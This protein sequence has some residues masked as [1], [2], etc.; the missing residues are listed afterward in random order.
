MKST[1]TDKYAEKQAQINLKRKEVITRYSSL[2][3]NMIFNWSTQGLDD[4]VWLM[5]SANYLFRTDNVRW[6][7]DP[8][9]LNWRIPYAPEMELCHDLQPLSF[10]LLTHSHKDHLDINL[11]SSLQHLP[12]RW[13]IPE[14]LLPLIKIKVPICDKQIIV[15][16]PLQPIEFEGFRITPF[17]G[18]HLVTHPDGTQTGVPEMGYMVEYKDKRWLFPGDTRVYDAKLFPLFGDIDILFAHLWLGR[19]AALVDPPQLIEA[20]CQFC[21]DLEPE[22][23]ILTHIEELGRDADDYWDSWHVNNILSQFQQKFPK[24]PIVPTHLGEGVRI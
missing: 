23:I 14:F 5:Y 15:P 21:A 3:A 12:I 8:L 13:I 17:K 9:S 16:H 4:M 24:I 22:R 10:V 11:L 20:F 6:A 7:I 2:W 1:T 19:G 18:Q